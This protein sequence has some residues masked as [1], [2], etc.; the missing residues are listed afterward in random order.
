MPNT[1]LKKSLLFLHRKLTDWIYT[2]R[3]VKYAYF[4]SAKFFSNHGLQPLLAGSAFRNQRRWEVQGT[5]GSQ[6][7]PETFL[8]ENQSLP[9]LFR[10]V[11]PY[12]PKESAIL[13]LGCNVGRSL[14]YLFKQGYQNLTGI[15]I[16]AKAVEL[17]KKAYPEMTKQ[18]KVIVGDAVQEIKKQPSAAFDLV[19]CHSVMVNIHPKFNSIFAD[20]A[21]VSR[22]FVLMLESEGSIT[23]YPR[24][25][26]KMIEQHG[27][28]QIVYK[29]FRGSCESLPIPFLDD[30]IYHNNTI[31]LFVKK[32]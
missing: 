7:N 32:Q 11:L 9:E 20:M 29:H 4:Q 16:G 13:E 6:D 12:L 26:Q 30:D 25:F 19:F 3:R 10:D 17:G 2:H 24:D 5:E 22:K 1:N 15:E 27:Y 21:R 28:K 14:N 18:A 31:R 23:A 8:K